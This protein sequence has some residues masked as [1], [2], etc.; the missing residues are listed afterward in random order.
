MKYDKLNPAALYSVQS[1]DIEDLRP[2]DIIWIDLNG[3]LHNYSVHNGYIEKKI[4]LTILNN[5]EFTPIN[6][7]ETYRE[8]LY[9][10]IRV[11]SFR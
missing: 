9:S 11:S 7:I 3:R 5:V 4:M 6:K 10:K 1:S 8:G 2:Q